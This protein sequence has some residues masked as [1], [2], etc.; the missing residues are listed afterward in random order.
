MTLYLLTQNG[1]STN[2]A[3]FYTMAAPASRI[4]QLCHTRL[5]LIA[6]ASCIH[7]YTTYPPSET[8]LADALAV[9][10]LDEWVQRLAKGIH[11]EA[12]LSQGFMVQ[13]VTAVKDES[14]LHHAVIDALVV[15]L[16]EL[17]P[18][19]EDCKAMC[20]LTGCVGVLRNCDRVGLLGLAGLAWVVPLKLGGSQ[21]CE[22]LV[23]GDLPRSKYCSSWS[24]TFNDMHCQQVV[25]LGVCK[26][27]WLDAAYTWMLCMKIGMKGNRSCSSNR[28][29]LPAQQVLVFCLCSQYKS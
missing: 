7:K 10:L 13:Q 4:N 19:C 12:N 22:N 29:Q 17:I 8:P 20:I 15:I 26:T 16:L 25:L 5:T 1:E 24:P 3:T 11:Y 9:G 18:L 6:N 23:S 2:N 14:R 28:E 27:R 21:V